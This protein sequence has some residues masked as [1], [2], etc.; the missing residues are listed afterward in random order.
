M[1]VEGSL[2]EQAIRGIVERLLKA[3]AGSGDD[4]RSVEW[5]LKAVCGSKRYMAIVEWLLKA[6]SWSKRNLGLLNGC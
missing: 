5:L 6:V 4:N 3:G 1:V 2:R